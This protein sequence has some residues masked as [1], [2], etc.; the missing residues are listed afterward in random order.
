MALL[1]SF[2]TDAMSESSPSLRHAPSEG[3]ARVRL[4]CFAHAGAGASSFNGWPQYLRPDIHL[5]KAQLPG[6]EDNNATP[7]FTEIE[8]LIAHLLPQLDP[9]L[10]RPLAIYG[11]SMGALVAFEI[12]RALRRHR[13]VQP[14][15]LFVSGRRAPHKPLRHPFLHRLCDADLVAHLRNMG[16]TS[17][18]LL[19]KPKWRDRFLPTMRA[20]LQLSDI[21]DYRDEPRLACP[22]YAFLGEE[23]HEMYREDWESWIDQ[24]DGHFER[25]LL[26]GGH[27]FSLPVQALLVARIAE[28]LDSLPLRVGQPPMMPTPAGPIRALD[29]ASMTS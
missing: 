25:A 2:G 16:G 21:Y 17:A 5:V 13:N 29:N 14:V 9:L 20:D 4:L 24:A 11:H 27:I 26:P 3:I 22:L 7:P 8:P 1:I 18:D 10:D 6:R 28:I 15:A 19:D 12:T 23:D